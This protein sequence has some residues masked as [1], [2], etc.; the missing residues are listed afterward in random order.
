MGSLHQAM[1]HSLYNVKNVCFL[2]LLKVKIWNNIIHFSSLVRW[3]FLYTMIKARLL[4]SFVNKFY[5]RIILQILLLRIL[6]FG[7][8][9]EQMKSTISGE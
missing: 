3:F 7:H 4:M 2:L 9:I 5:V 1:A 8:G 6:L